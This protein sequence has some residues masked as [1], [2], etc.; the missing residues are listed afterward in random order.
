[1]GFFVGAAM[2]RWLAVAALCSLVAFAFGQDDD[3]KLKIDASEAKLL[4]LTNAERKKENL[5]P[6]KAS[7]LL[8]KVARAHS[9]NMAKQGKLNHD[10]DDKS[11]FDRMKDAG[12]SFGRAGENIA[13]G[14]ANLSMA[15]VLKIWMDSEGHRMNILHKDY[16]EIGLGIARNDKGEVYFTQVFATPLR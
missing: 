16:L 12:Y 3:K 10:L 2:I 5:P 8:F 7:A 15:D 1:V 9:R 6:L 13:F 14:G 4:E 11:P